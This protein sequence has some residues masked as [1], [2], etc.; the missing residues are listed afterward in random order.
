MTEIKT[1]NVI[2]TEIKDIV[3]HEEFDKAYM[4]SLNSCS[5][6]MKEKE[7][8]AK[9]YCS[10]YCTNDCYSKQKHYFEQYVSLVRNPETL[11]VE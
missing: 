11:Y 9:K 6:L 3:K 8:K 4:D 2:V 7:I 10:K 1:K 5:H